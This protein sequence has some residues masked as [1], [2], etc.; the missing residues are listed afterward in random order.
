M[1][2]KN[3]VNENTIM[4]KTEHGSLSK[5]KTK[6]DRGLGWATWQRPFVLFFSLKA[7]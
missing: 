5:Q 3:G 1:E 2:I 7:G 6:S 4:L